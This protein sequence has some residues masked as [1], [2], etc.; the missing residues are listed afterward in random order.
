M[1]ETETKDQVQEEAQ[2][3]QQEEQSETTNEKD[4][5]KESDES[6]LF[7]LPDGRKLAGDQL[8]EEYL[9]LN[10]EFTR[11]SQKLSEYERERVET[12]ARNKKSAD[13]AVSKSRLLADVDPTVKDAIIQIVSPVIQE[14]LG[15]REKAETRRRDQENFDSRLTSLEKKYPGGNGLPKFDKIKILQ[16]MQEPSNEIYDPEL[17][18]QRLNWDAWLDAQI[19][20]AMKGKSGSSS[21]ESTST[22]PPKAPGTGKTPTTWSEATR[23]A[24][25]RF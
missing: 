4:V 18:F 2:T 9:K 20:A 24:I 15:E 14:A 22:E 8:R 17:L 7:E 10:S 5:N 3:G 11:R 21:T 25:S 12:E 1:D 23:N 13:E 6:N 19:R 16:K